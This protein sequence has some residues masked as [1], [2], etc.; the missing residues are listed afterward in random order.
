MSESTHGETARWDVRLA[1]SARNLDSL[2]PRVVPAM[3]EFLYGPLAENPYRL[4]KPLRGDFEGSYG[5]RRGSYRVLFDVD[6]T[7]HVVLVY[8]VSARATAYRP[9][10]G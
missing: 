5:A 9:G 7:K 2:S 10:T 3:V 6:E 1:P 4:G 8:R